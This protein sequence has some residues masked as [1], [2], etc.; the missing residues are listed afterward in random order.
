MGYILLCTTNDDEMMRKMGIKFHQN[1]NIE[2]HYM[3]L[4]LSLN[5]IYFNPNSI[6]FKFLNWIQKHQIQFKFNSNPIQFNWTHILFYSISIK[7]KQDTNWS[8]KV[9]KFDCYFHHLWLSCGK[10]NSKN[11]K[12]INLKIFLSIPFKT[13]QLYLDRTNLIDPKVT[14]PPPTPILVPML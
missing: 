8:K 9:F 2:W 3:Q 14:L 13:N 4:E 11:F 12:D 10:K 7:N 5:L 1:E 6:E